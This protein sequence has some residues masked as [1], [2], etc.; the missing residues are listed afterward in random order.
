M[1]LGAVQLLGT[2]YRYGG[3]SA[4]TGLDCS[5]F[6]SAVVAQATGLK[7]TGS[8]R[9][10]AQATRRVKRDELRVGDLLFFNSRG[11]QYGHVGIYVGEGRFAHAPHTGT[12]VRIDDL[13]E[14]RWKRLTG[15]HRLPLRFAK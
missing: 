7:L 9:D 6:V 2:P 11:R 8:A 3:K 13:S 15:I 10:Q 4:K 5:G 12:V 14:R 1:L